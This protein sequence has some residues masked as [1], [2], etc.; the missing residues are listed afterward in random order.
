MFF[1]IVLGIASVGIITL[2]IGGY[3]RMQRGGPDKV[4]GALMIAVSII[5]AI[6]LALWATMPEMP[7]SQV[8]EVTLSPP[9]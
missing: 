8:D 2:A 9:D 6:N 4:K 7:A 1:Q 5:T 3:K